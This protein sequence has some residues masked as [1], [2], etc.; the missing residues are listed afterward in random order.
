MSRKISVICAPAPKPNPGMASV[1]FA[2]YALSRRY[3]FAEQVTYYQLYPH[4]ELHSRARTDLEREIRTRQSLP[5][6]YRNF[7]HGLEDIFASDRIVF[8]GDFLHAADY[9]EAAAR[10][11]VKIGLAG[12]FE[13]A[14]GRVRNHYFLRNAPAEIW[15]RVLAFGGNLLFNRLGHYADGSYASQVQ[16]F[17]QKVGKVWMRDVYSAA[18]VNELRN[19]YEFSYLGC[20]GSLLLTSEDLEQLPY[21]N[22]YDHVG[23]GK[24]H[25]G[26]FFGRNKCNPAIMARFAR[27]L[28][29][30]LGIK[31]QWIP[32]G[33][34]KGF[35]RM[36]KKV[37]RRF[38]GMEIREYPTPPTLGDLQRMLG[39]CDVVIS[40][41][42]HVCVNAWRLGVPAV[43]LGQAL[44]RQPDNINSGNA[45]AWR[46]KRQVFY[47][48]HDAMEYYVYIEELADRSWRRKRLEQLVALLQKD[49]YRQAVSSRIRA[50]AAAVEQSLVQ[51]LLPH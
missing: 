6:E 47:G 14:L 38:S 32:W 9:H 29:R 50:R 41:T 33:L 23:A 5:F 46:D 11:L 30:R 1:D 20:D 16:Q 35:G 49:S 17:F 45:F 28:C 48:M 40:D 44:V 34:S 31:G 51:A 12:S 7:R 42:Y 2:F 39:H 25:A 8:W 10:R 3:G 24:G 36:K 19:D 15:P 21:N 37:G 13:E 26:I 22:C 4:D 27:D 18:R 43:C